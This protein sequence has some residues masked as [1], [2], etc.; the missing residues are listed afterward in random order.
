LNG[1]DNLSKKK[2]IIIGARSLDIKEEKAGF[3]TLFGGMGR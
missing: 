1:L 2:L 3:G